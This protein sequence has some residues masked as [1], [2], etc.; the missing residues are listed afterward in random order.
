M[1][2]KINALHLDE[3]SIMTLAIPSRDGALEV[4]FRHQICNPYERSLLENAHQVE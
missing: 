1:R 4:P 3:A 2:R